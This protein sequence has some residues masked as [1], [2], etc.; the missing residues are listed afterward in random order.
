MLIQEKKVYRQH[1]KSTWH[2]FIP[3]GARRK[4]LDQILA[5]LL[6]EG[7]NF[8]VCSFHWIAA[9]WHTLISL[10]KCRHPLLFWDTLRYTH[11]ADRWYTGPVG[12][13]NLVMLLVPYMAAI[14]AKQDMVGYLIWHL[15][16]IFRQSYRT[17]T[18]T[19]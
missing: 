16:V 19:Q 3:R 10:P 8:F 2:I 7:S 1:F 9:N 14:M 18:E 15:I 6:S 13:P 17:Y 12:D 11:G 4:C 5:L